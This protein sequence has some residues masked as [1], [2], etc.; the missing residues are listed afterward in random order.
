MGLDRIKFP[1]T[2][3]SEDVDVRY[4]GREAIKTSSFISTSGTP[5]R[6]SNYSAEME[7]IP[8]ICFSLSRDE[9]A[10]MSKRGEIYWDEQGSIKRVDVAE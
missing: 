9:I 3:L 1:P 10:N 8:K 5:K 7:A 6:R 4:V 2:L